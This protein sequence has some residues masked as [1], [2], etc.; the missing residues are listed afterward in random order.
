MEN[1]YSSLWMIPDYDSVIE[2]VNEG[3]KLPGFIAARAMEAIR[4]VRAAQQRDQ[5]EITRDMKTLTKRI[6]DLE[7][8]S[9]ELLRKYNIR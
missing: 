3:R 4:V 5:G 1:T 2:I 9:R 6:S 8:R 7:K